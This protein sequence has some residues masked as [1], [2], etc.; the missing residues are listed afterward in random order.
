MKELK[1]VEGDVREPIGEGVKYI[2]HI[3]NDQGCMKIY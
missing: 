2:C 1:Y 3:C